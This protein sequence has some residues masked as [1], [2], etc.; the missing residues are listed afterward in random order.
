MNRIMRFSL[1]PATLLFTYV[2]FFLYEKSEGGYPYLYNKEGAKYTYKIIYI[3]GEHVIEYA[4]SSYGAIVANDVY[5]N[6][7]IQNCFYIIG[8]SGNNNTYFLIDK[9]NNHVDAGLNRNQL[10]G[11]LKERQI[12]ID[13]INGSNDLSVRKQLY[14]ECDAHP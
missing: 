3:D 8:R 12:D 10:I 1:I 7:I 9:N 6:S 11:I 14:A 13:L 5:R 4:E 2:I